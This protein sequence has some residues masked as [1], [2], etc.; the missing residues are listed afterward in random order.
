ME[1]QNKDDTDKKHPGGKEFLIP[2]LRAFNRFAIPALL[3]VALFLFFANVPLAYILGY[4]ILLMITY[5]IVAIGSAD[6]ESQD[7]KR[8]GS[9][10]FLLF[11]LNALLFAV[12]FT[13]LRKYG[14]QRHAA[15]S[16]LLVLLIFNILFFEIRYRFLV[17]KL[18]QLLRFPTVSVS[19][20]WVLR[21]SALFVFILC[22]SLVI[23]EYSAEPQKQTGK[24]QS[25][26]TGMISTVAPDQQDIGT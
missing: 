19:A 25:E 13:T 3:L 5:S 18:E 16:I 14:M 21:T 15:Q 11:A 26:I 8:E 20:A 1:N 4:I 2:F 10:L 12:T 6:P 23:G 9:H 17:R 24:S 22:I 7:L